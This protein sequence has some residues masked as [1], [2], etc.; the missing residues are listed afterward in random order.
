MKTQWPK[1]VKL[2]KE[3]KKCDRF[4]HAVDI[5]RKLGFSKATFHRL[6]DTMKAKL[7]APV[8][9][10]RKLGY[11]YDPEKRE[12]F[13]LPG[14]WFSEDELQALLI[15][16][17][18]TDSLQNG[19]FSEIMAPLHEC[20]DEL[21]EAQE[22]DKKSWCEKIKIVPVAFRKSNPGIFKTVAEAILHEKK[23]GIIYWKYHDKS[24][25]IRVVSPQKIIR[26]KDNWYLDAFCHKDNI[27]KTFSINRIEKAEISDTQ[28][29]LIPQDEL[30]TY[31][32][33]T[34]G[35]FSGN[36]VKTAVIEFRNYAAY[37]VLQEEW[38]PKQIIK[39]IEKDRIQL[40]IPYGHSRELIMDILR[41]GNEAEVISPPELRDE[42]TQIINDTH[43]LYSKKSVSLIET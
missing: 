39:E 2:H 14:I 23:L 22:I 33:S 43:S 5:Y 37:E 19:F 31:Y 42:I 10:D 7:R 21:L 16:S 20:L 12:S 30:E 6:I 34:Y 41:W 40:E 38:H 18:I 29:K 17:N 1:I 27:L 36:S 4:Y 32:N 8:I 35:I 15:L 26:Y 25:V 11:K 3:F 13:E 24:N 9:S 28:S